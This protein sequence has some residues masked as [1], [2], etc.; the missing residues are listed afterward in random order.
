VDE[1][2]RNLT[3]QYEGQSLQYENMCS[4]WLDSCQQ[5]DILE[6]GDLLEDVETGKTRI[7]YPVS[8]NPVS[9]KMMP[10]GHFLGGVEFVPGRSDLQS[11]KSV[12]L[13]YFV[14][15]G[16]DIDVQK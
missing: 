12:L 6:L 4:K 1:V 8:L 16:S 3:I 14:K 2:I 9:F 11:A 5:N 10:T 15:S 13:Y 7:G